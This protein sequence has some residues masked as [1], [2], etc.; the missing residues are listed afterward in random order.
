MLI[1]HGLHPCAT[2]VLSNRDRVFQSM[3]RQKSNSPW[4]ASVILLPAGPHSWFISSI[5]WL[6]VYYWQ[7]TLI[8]GDRVFLCVCLCLCKCRNYSVIHTKLKCIVRHHSQHFVAHYSHVSI[9]CSEIA[10]TCWANWTPDFNLHI[11]KCMHLSAC[12][13]QF[14]LI[15]SCFSLQMTKGYPWLLKFWGI[16]LCIAEKIVS[17]SIN[18]TVGTK[19]LCDLLWKTIG[20]INCS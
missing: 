10:L 16:Q 3:S 14:E 11:T 1:Q 8:S 9:R 19:M 20:D 18:V 6:H 4:S 15:V 12:L 13:L 2:G 7:F 5:C 17:I